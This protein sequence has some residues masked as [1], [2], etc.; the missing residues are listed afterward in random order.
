MVRFKRNEVQLSSVLV[1]PK[2][3]ESAKPLLD[4]IE[5]SRVSSSE[6]GQQMK[7]SIMILD[8]F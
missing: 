2:Y 5:N 4:F 3:E 1:S 7:N 8:I 6:E